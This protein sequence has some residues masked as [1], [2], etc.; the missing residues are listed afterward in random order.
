MK[1]Q[2]KFYSAHLAQAD[3]SLLPFPTAHFDVVMTVHV[4]HLIAP[5]REALRELQRV[6]VPGGVYLNVKTWGTVGKP[7]RGQMREF[8]RGWLEAQGVNPRLPGVQ[9]DEEFLRELRSQ[10]AQVTEVEVVH[11]P[12][13]FT[14][15]GELERFASRVY[16]DTWYIP[17]DIFE[18]SIKEL[19]AWV[20]D[21]FG[22][23]D[24][25]RADEVRFAID[26]ARFESWRTRQ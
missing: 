20:D 5:W 3:G 21:E 23:L 26:V 8:W 13:E 10:G 4:M 1:L 11:Y 17:D 18:A 19:R 15:R 25:P 24:Q 14:L 16:S 6:L 12:L 9:D 22:N 7:I 2:E